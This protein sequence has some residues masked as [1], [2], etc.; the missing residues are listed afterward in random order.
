MQNA[1]QTSYRNRALAALSGAAVTAAMICGFVAVEPAH[2][3]TAA[4]IQAQA[5]AAQQELSA[6]EEMANGYYSDYIQS[7]A[8]YETA[9]TGRDAA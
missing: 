7:L 6:M 4:E 3:D 9:S 1:L 5:D 2:A 8:D